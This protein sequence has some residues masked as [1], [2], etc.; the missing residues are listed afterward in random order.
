M[1]ALFRNNNDYLIVFL[2]H[3]TYGLLWCPCKVINK[4]G[5]YSRLI[6]YK[7]SVDVQMESTGYR[8][9]PLIKGK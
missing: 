3:Q 5:G 4:I 9:I 6:L 7:P 8:R 2:Q 1:S